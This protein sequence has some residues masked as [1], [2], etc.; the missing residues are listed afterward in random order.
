MGLRVDAVSCN[1]FKSTEI[2][3]CHSIGHETGANDSQRFRFD[4]VTRTQS[5]II[6]TFG[7]IGFLG[8][9]GELEIKS[10]SCIHIYTFPGDGCGFIQNTYIFVFSV[11]LFDHLINTN[12]DY[13]NVIIF[14]SLQ[15]SL[16]SRHILQILYPI[17]RLLSYLLQ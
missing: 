2:S 9:R 7:V 1:F 4:Y 6:T 3:K 15:F 11:L 16:H 14:E 17:F 8:L 13:E 10:S 12:A 5:I